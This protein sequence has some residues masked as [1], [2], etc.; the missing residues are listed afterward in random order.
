MEAQN[1][2]ALSLDHQ[3]FGDEGLA[4]LKVLSSNLST[5]I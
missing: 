4:E 1:P 2:E 5:L 3:K